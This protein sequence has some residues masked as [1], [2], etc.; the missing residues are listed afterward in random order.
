MQFGRFLT[1]PVIAEIVLIYAVNNVHDT[2]LASDP[3]EPRE[4][5]VF[6][7]E[8]AVRVVLYI[9]RVI[10]FM[11]LDI[12]VRNGELIHESFGIAFVGFGDGSGISGDG[13]GVR[14]QYAVGGP[15]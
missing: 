3:V 8:T 7:M 12:F 1:R 13:D 11:R 10:E 6:A 5:L 2:A 15:R 4:Q 9:I 14:P